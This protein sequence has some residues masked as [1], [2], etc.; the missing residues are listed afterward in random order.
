[1]RY[2]YL[3]GKILPET[4]ARVSPFDRGLLYGDAVF[5]TVRVYDGRAHA[6][7]AHLARL[8][9]SCDLTGIPYPADVAWG[10]EVV[11]ALLRANGLREASVRIT[12]TRG[13]GP[14]FAPMQD[15]TP[16]VMA[17]A[18]PVP[19]A[20]ELYEEGVAVLLS[21]V[22]KTP[23]ATLDPRL[24]SVN[25]LPH[26]LARAEAKR[27]G[28]FEALLRGDDGEE[29]VEGTT[30]NLFL[31]KDGIVL[32]PPLSSG[33]LD[34]LTR[35]DVLAVLLD[36]AR[37]VEERPLYPRDL[38]EADEVFLTASVAEVLPVVRID[39]APVGDGKPGKVAREALQAY[40]AWVT[41]TA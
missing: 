16:T 20:P 6:L 32:T 37:H 19:Y 9:R 7:D 26:V 38:Q 33:I 3:D 12:V 23:A 8:R 35:R 30:S 18:T 14:G 10:S 13:T 4:E 40:R 22:R 17:I 31:V 21:Q 11:P 1:M 27:A 2:V 41:R 15:V 39:G 24:K 34:G 29:V 5:E 36:Q 25:Y 28:A